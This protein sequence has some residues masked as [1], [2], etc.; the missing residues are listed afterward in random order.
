[1]TTKSASL[2]IFC[3]GPVSFLVPPRGT[4][5][6]WQTTARLLQSF[7]AAATVLMKVMVDANTPAS[8]RVPRLRSIQSGAIARTDLEC[9]IRKVSPFSLKA[10]PISLLNTGEPMRCDA[11]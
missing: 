9:P 6:I 8:T 3:V 11:S 7:P 1:M 2:Q 10:L 4:D 5:S